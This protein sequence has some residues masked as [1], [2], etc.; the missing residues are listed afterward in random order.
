[1]ATALEDFLGIL[2][3][4]GVVE[5]EVQELLTEVVELEEDAGEETDSC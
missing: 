3:T 1:V 5:V 4:R 2:E